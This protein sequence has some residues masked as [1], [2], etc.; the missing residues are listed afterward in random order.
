MLGGFVKVDDLCTELVVPDLTNFTLKPYIAPGA[1]RN[2]RDV[3]VQ[4]EM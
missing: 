1:K 4:I 2:I 3:S